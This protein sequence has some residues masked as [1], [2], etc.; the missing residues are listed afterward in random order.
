[1]LAA[2]PRRTAGALSADYIWQPDLQPCLLSST[3]SLAAGGGLLED[4]RAAS[5]FRNSTQ[6]MP[7]EEVPC[8]GILMHQTVLLP[9]QA[10]PAGKPGRCVWVLGHVHTLVHRA[11]QPVWLRR[12]P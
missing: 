11:E 2:G 10:L 3:D 6:V 7:R 8:S 1:M 5:S 4:T 12:C 9:G